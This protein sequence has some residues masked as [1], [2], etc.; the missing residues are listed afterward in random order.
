MNRA[1]REISRRQAGLLMLGS[2]GAAAWMSATAH[3]AVQPTTAAA[4]SSPPSPPSTPQ[5]PPKHDPRAVAPARLTLPAKGAAPGPM[6]DLDTL[7][8]RGRT[9][10][11]TLGVRIVVDGYQTPTT[12]IR[13]DRQVEIRE[14]QFDSAAIVFPVLATTGSSIT[15]INAVESRL[16]FDDIDQDAS[17]VYRE[18]YHSGTRLARWVLLNKRGRQ[19]ELELKVPMTVWET[20]F[21]EQASYNVP[22]P[23]DNQWSPTAAST[24]EPQMF[25]D[26]AHPAVTALLER[27]TGGEPAKS[28]PPVLFAKYAAGQVAELI[29]PALGAG[30]AATRTSV[31]TGFDILGASTAIEQRQGTIFDVP[32]A[33]VAVYRAA[34]LPARLV[35]GRELDSAKGGGGSALS[36]RA[37]RGADLHAWCEFCLYDPA[38]KKELW[39]PVDPLRMRATSSRAPDLSRPWRYFG[40]HDQLGDTLPFSFTF[41]PP[42][43]VVAHGAVAFWGWTTM[44]D[45]QSATQSLTF[46]DNATPR[47]PDDPPVGE[48]PVSPSRK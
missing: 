35:I 28:L 21:D 9:Q 24:F 32:A 1:E 12:Q 13:R 31:F 19:V 42:T 17:P 6:P 4:P 45:S 34:G 11:R 27:I 14:L 43:T 2:I 41:H 5:V 37:S 3:G 30:Q 25:I 33:L 29:A 20:I 38:T 48:R 47:R 23:K 8:T 16:K 26:H 15:D 22:W 44:P 18:G 10:A 7:I 39:V 46:Q 40:T 36:G